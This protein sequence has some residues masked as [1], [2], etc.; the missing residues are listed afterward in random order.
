[1]TCGIIEFW[2]NRWKKKKNPPSLFILF[3][4]TILDLP[5]VLSINS[6]DEHKKEKKQKKKN[7]NKKKKKKEKKDKKHT[8]SDDDDDPSPPGDAPMVVCLSG[9]TDD[10]T[11][12][13]MHLDGKFSGALSFAFLTVMKDHDNDVTVRNLLKGLRKALETAQKKTRLKQLPQLT[14]TRGVELDTRFEI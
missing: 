5:H 12:A 7:K 13:D 2:W 8:D 9:C 3:S 6:K 11:S 4:G 14:Y 10:S 1:M